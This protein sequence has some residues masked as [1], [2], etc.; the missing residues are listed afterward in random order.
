MDSFERP[1][2]LAIQLALEPLQSLVSHGLGSVE[3][4]LKALRRE[5]N[6]VQAVK[7]ELTQALSE[8]AQVHALL[9]QRVTRLEGTVQGITAAAAVKPA[10][11]TTAPALAP[12]RE[13]TPVSK[14]PWIVAAVAAVVTAGVLGY[15]LPRPGSGSVRYVAVPTATDGA[16]AAPSEVPPPAAVVV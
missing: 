15:A 12:H 1:P 9:T 6:N 4:E 14:G 10:R 11:E 7:A 5:A 13:P 16:T 3:R 8:L 2:D